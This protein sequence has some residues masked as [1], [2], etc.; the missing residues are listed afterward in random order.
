MVQRC[1]LAQ[2]AQLKLRK[3]ELRTPEL[4]NKTLL[5]YFAIKHKFFKFLKI[6][7]SI[8][9]GNWL[10]GNFHRTDWSKSYLCSGLLVPKH[11]GSLWAAGELCFKVYIGRWDN[12]LDAEISYLLLLFRNSHVVSS[13]LYSYKYA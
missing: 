5:H 7:N 8:Y 9:R 12:I 1:E 10:L 2:S 11:R 4:R 6:S 3:P 13:K